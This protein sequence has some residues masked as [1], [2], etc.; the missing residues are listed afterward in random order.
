M[1][2]VS[3]PFP[4]IF[5]FC[6]L[7]VNLQKENEIVEKAYISFKIPGLEMMHTTT[8]QTKLYVIFIFVGICPGAFFFFKLKA[9]VEICDP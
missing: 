1:F 9:K 8:K 3:K 2:I 6:H 7:Y 5:C 4:S